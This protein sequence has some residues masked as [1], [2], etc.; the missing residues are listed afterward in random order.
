MGRSREHHFVPKFYLRYF[1]A[2]GKRINLFNFA[3]GKAIRGVSIKH[4]CSRHNFYDFAPKLEGAFSKLEAGAAGVI[5]KIKATTMVP[6]VG[7]SEWNSLTS[8]MVFQRLR[9]AR[10]GYTSD[11]GTDYFSKLMLENRPELSGID[12]NEIQIGHLYPVAIPLSVA[13]DM[14][15]M[16]T[17]L[18]MHLFVNNTRREFITSDDPVVAHN[19]YCEGITYR[20]VTGFASRGLQLFWPLS[21]IHL[22][23][24][25]DP[26][27][28]RVDRADHGHS[29]TKISS[30]RD[31]AQ[32][33]SLQILNAHENVYFLDAD[34]RGNAEQQCAGLSKERPRGRMVF[35]ET[36]AIPD[37]AGGESA[38][39]HQ[40]E[41]LLPLRLTVSAIRVRKAALAAPLGERANLYREKRDRA[42]KSGVDMPTGRYRVK[43]T[44][45][46]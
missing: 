42:P 6:N 13:A 16:I 26:E 8:F 34:V 32:F 7:S 27:V 36:E 46:R 35:V 43:T 24:L 14:I 40:F 9:T 39:L 31:V 20:G 2:D 23:L 18:Q 21:P 10:A 41:P 5:A 28:Y 44:T 11:A 33:N 4:Q 12:L 25:S 17:D 29:T 15:P 45:R 38:L 3:R 1:S 37:P 19:Q 22:L 30:E